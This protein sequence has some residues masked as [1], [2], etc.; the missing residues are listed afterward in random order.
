MTL[1]P[2]VVVS[3]P[4]EPPSPSPPLPPVPVPPLSTATVPTPIAPE[5]LPDIG[6]PVLPPVPVKAAVAKTKPSHDVK[7]HG[8]MQASS[9]PSA[10]KL[11]P[12]A[13]NQDPGVMTHPGYPTEAISRGETGTVMMLVEF[14]ASGNVARAEVVESSG[15]PLLDSSTRSYIRQNWHSPE[16]AGQKI[17]V[18]V[19]YKLT[20]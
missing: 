7:A 3:T 9:A 16:Y 6:V 13:S 4:S 19:E 11:A 20:H 15:I 17:T 10:P 1:E 5:K 2:M 18:P 12:M 14:N 8:T